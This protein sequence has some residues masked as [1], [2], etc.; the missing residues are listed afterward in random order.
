MERASNSFAMCGPTWERSTCCCGCIRWLSS[1]PG[2]FRRNNFAIG[3]DRR[4]T[5]PRDDL[6]TRT[7]VKHC[8]ECAST[9]IFRDLR[10]S[11][12]SHE[13]SEPASNALRRSSRSHTN[14]RKCSQVITQ[15]YWLDNYSSHPGWGK[16]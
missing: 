11:H 6:L 10:S 2:T 16:D 1:G 14:V 4:G 9:S 15:E 8:N 13:N 7:A 12:L 5:T 3:A